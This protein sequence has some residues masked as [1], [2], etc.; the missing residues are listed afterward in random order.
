MTDEERKK[1][2][3]E[4][5]D[6]SGSGAGPCFLLAALCFGIFFIPFKYAHYFLWAGIAFSVLCG[7][8]IFFGAKRITDTQFDEALTKMLDAIKLKSLQ[9]AGIEEE[10]LISKQLLIRGPRYH[11]T[12]GLDFQSK[13]GEDKIWRYSLVDIT[14]LNLTAHQIIAYQCCLDLIQEKPINETTNEYFYKDIVSISTKTVSRTYVIAKGKRKG[15]QVSSASAEVVSL[16]TS[17]GTSIDAS[18]RDPKLIELWGG[19]G[20]ELPNTDAEIAIAAVRKVLREKKA[21]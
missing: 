2:T 20:G 9:K 5:F 12:S 19:K 10:E 21:T 16:T 13:I 8:A 3:K 7:L 17:G 6:E 4:Y 1:K 15:E 18:M 14:V 11:D